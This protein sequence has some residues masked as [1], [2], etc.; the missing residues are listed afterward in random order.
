MLK[1]QLMLDL[2]VI[3]VDL[4][5][6]ILNTKIRVSISICTYTYSHTI[7]NKLTSYP[8]IKSKQATPHATV[9][10]MILV[11]YNVPH[12]SNHFPTTICT[13]DQPY[14]NRL[15]VGIRLLHHEHHDLQ[16][17]PTPRI[18]RRIGVGLVDGLVC[19]GEVCDF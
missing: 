4:P 13:L 5:V 6:A 12:M 11:Y 8:M 16:P 15:A 14:H 10:S 19:A 1:L 9:H 7:T 2:I 17:M 3:F 18:L